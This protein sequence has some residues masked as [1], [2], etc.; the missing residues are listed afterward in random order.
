MTFDERFT[1]DYHALA[2]LGLARIYKRQGNKEKTKN[3]ANKAL[4][5]AEYKSTIKEA[6]SLLK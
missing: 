3:Y 1:K 6:E 4:Q 2:Y 5:I